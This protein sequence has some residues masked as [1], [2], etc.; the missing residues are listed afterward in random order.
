MSFYTNAFQR[1]GKFFVRGYGDDG[2]PFDRIVTDYQPYIFLPS[3]NVDGGY[4]T[5]HGEPV[6]KKTF[7]NLREFYN[8]IKPF[9]EAENFNFYGMTNFV[10]TYLNDTW[11]G[12]V[13]Y[14]HDLISIVSLDIEVGSRNGFP[15]INAATEE[16]TAIT[17]VKN[18]KSITF[19]TKEFKPKQS[20]SQYVQCADEQDLL[21]QFLKCWNSDAWRPDIVTGW[22]IDLFDIPYL[23]HRITNLLGGHVAQR[24]SPFNH[25]EQ[26]EVIRAKG[27]TYKNFDD[28]KEVVYDLGGIATLDYLQLYKK[29]TFTNHPSYSLNNIAK[30]ELKKTKVP[31]KGSLDDL[32]DNDPQTFYEYNIED[33]FLV[34]ELEDAKSYIKFIVSLAYEAKVN[35]NDAMGTLRPWDVIIHNFLLDRQIVIPQYQRKLA[36]PIPGGYVKNSQIGLHYWIVSFDFTSLYPSIIAQ[37]N[38]SPETYAGKEGATDPEHIVERQIWPTIEEVYSYCANGTK[39]KKDHQGFIPEIIELYTKKRADLKKEAGRLKKAGNKKE[40]AIF[41]NQQQAVKIL[42]NGLYG[43]LSNEYFRWYDADLAEAVTTTSQVC[44]RYVEKHVNVWFN[45]LLKTED[46]DYVIAADTDSVYITLDD[47]LTKANLKSK[48]VQKIVD[49]INKICEEKLG[50]FIQSLCDDVCRKFNVFKPKLNM[51]H[52]A[53]AEK[54][55]W[56]APKMYVMNLWQFEGERFAEPKLKVKGIEIVRSSTPPL[57]KEKLTE[58]I[59]I[60]MNKDEQTLQEYV[61]KFKNEYRTLPFEQIAN[62]RSVDGIVKYGDPNTVCIKGTPFHVRGALVYNF[63]V[64]SLGLEKKYKLIQDK[65]KIRFVYMKEGNPFNTHVLAAHETIPE[66][67]EAAEWVDYDTQF[68]KTFIHPLESLTNLVGWRLIPIND[69]ADFL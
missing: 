6:T 60:I 23:I 35:Y 31:Y 62:P 30:A 51:K 26:R 11:P 25:L 65:E 48:D 44:T 66:E 50:P 28:R 9:K 58:A 18:G 3:K 36:R 29:L 46:I 43:A 68:N 20:R 7:K 40:A 61:E 4:R 59:K 24:L 21:R 27:S 63:A 17:M 34:S 8:Y 14:N 57:C 16:V 53:I 39:Y 13:Q 64:K 54:V 38:I 42:N 47:L 45:E 19:G 5:I 67:F 12:K 37:H 55:I 22:S 52:E 2:L 15:D 41:D 49:N 10:Y 1:N 33:S 32:Y 69:L 56:R